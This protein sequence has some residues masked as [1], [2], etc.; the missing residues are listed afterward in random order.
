MH[1]TVVIGSLKKKHDSG[2]SS[3]SGD[4][5]E[6]DIESAISGTPISGTPITI[7]SGTSGRMVID[8][9]LVIFSGG[10]ST[11]MVSLCE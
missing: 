6:L 10:S 4:E 2:V 1:M 11:T 5:S 3:A 7:S 9:C 8:S